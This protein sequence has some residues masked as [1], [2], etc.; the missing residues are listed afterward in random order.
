MALYFSS[1]FALVAGVSKGWGFSTMIH[2]GIEGRGTLFSSGEP[3]SRGGEGHLWGTKGNSCCVFKH[4]LDLSRKLLERTF[5]KQ[6]A[7]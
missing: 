1:R 5:Q 7:A 6:E 3:M 4:K 2:V